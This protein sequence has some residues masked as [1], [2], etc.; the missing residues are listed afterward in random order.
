MAKYLMIFFVSCIGFNSPLFCIFDLQAIESMSDNSFKEYT[1]DENI[2]GLKKE[3]LENL[4]KNAIDNLKSTHVVDLK[5]EKNTIAF[6]L[7]IGFLGFDLDVKNIM[8]LNKIDDLILIRKTMVSLAEKSKNT[9]RVMDNLIR[10][11]KLKIYSEA[12]GPYFLENF[13]LLQKALGRSSI[14]NFV[15]LASNPE[16]L[17][18]FASVSNS[19]EFNENFLET[20]T[21]MSNHR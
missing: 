7:N 14:E 18:L 12:K 17:A 19:S 1:K 11:F 4:I 8:E 10:L 9:Q 15:N 21:Q 16:Y 3:Y 13:L 20:I 2:N 5:E 6:F